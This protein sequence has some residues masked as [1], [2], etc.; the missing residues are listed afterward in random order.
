MAEDYNT[1]LARRTAQFTQY[2]ERMRQRARAEVKG[3]CFSVFDEEQTGVRSQPARSV[4]RAKKLA[5]SPGTGGSMDART[6]ES[7]SWPEDGWR[8]DQ[9]P[10]AKRFVQF[11]F[12]NKWFIMDLPRSTLTPDE[13]RRLI[14][15][16]TGFFYLKDRPA[17]AA[18]LTSECQVNLH[19]PFC[20]V[21]LY[22][23][24]R[25]AA[26]DMAYVFFSLWHFPV[27]WQFYFTA[28]SG[29][30]PAVHFEDGIPLA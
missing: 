7:D 12:L 19:D 20:K 10:G 1:E 11:G 29:G 22:N 18:S 21:Y 8:D 25:N 6:Y 2:L 26:E 5:L 27:D 4:S 28:F 23:E 24:E 30:D 9:D 13:A 14:R 16:R 17:F 3:N 15:D